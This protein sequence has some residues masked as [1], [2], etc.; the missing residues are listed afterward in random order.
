[1]SDNNEYQGRIVV[2]TGASSGFG[3]GTALELAKRGASVV[4]AARSPEALTELA[5]EC[6]TAGGRAMA[7]PTDVSDRN[8]VA[9]LTD[10]AVARFGRIDVWI[11]GAGVAAVGRF[12]QVPLED[13]EQVIRTDLLGVTYG[14]HHAM[15][16]FRARG[17]GTLINIA[18]AL[19]KIP[20]PLYASY[21]ASKFGVV[22]LGDALRQEL[23][24]EKITDI[25]VCTVM[26]MAHETEFFEHAGNYTGKKAVPIPPTYDPKTTIDELVRL[27][28]EPEDEVITGWQGG[29]FSFL[30]RLMP[31]AIEKLMAGNTNAVQMGESM[32]APKTSG[33][34]HQP[35]KA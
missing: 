7:V 23:G 5:Q 33:I 17:K 31:K 32:P 21:V 25:R 22:G 13:H 4:L 20:T 26:P 9:A 11:N 15:S 12:D 1:M 6:E 3:R 35:S 28:V 14:S 16:H 27:V 8:A 24:E 30:H 29:P 2:I 34:I 19:G 18:S 10:K